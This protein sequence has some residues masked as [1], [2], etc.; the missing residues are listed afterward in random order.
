MEDN[1]KKDSVSNSYTPSQQQEYIHEIIHDADNGGDQIADLT[2]IG[3]VIVS[4][5][6]LTWPPRCFFYSYL[7]HMCSLITY[8]TAV[9]KRYHTT[10]LQPIE[11]C[12]NEHQ[13]VKLL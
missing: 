7:V 4:Q 13:L 8:L 1:T 3:H 2:N 12:N 5:V 11:I 10:L 6:T 9:T